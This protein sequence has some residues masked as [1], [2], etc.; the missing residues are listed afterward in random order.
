MFF[1]IKFLS[2]FVPFP[3]NVLNILN[4]CDFFFK[5]GRRG[6]WR[7]HCSK[8]WLQPGFSVDLIKGLQM[9]RAKSK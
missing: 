9:S 4:D 1:K 7:E 5:L 3:N 2:S 6:I 8:K